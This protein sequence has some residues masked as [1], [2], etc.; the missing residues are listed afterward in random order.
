MTRRTDRGTGPSYPILKNSLSKVK[1][2]KQNK[3]SLTAL[4]TAYARAYH[5]V[6]GEAKIF[7]DHL[8]YHFFTAEERADLERNLAE[9]LKFFDPERAASCPDQASALA[10][11]MRIQGCPATISRS[12]Y[13]EDCLETAMQKGVCQYVILGAGMDTFAFRRPDLSG[14]LEVFEIDHPLTQAF[15]LSRL[16]ELGWEMPGHMHFIPVDFTK[17]NL[18][19]ALGQSS[20]DPGKL[21]F[22]SWLGVTIYLDR[23]EV[24]ATLRAIAGIAP[25]GSQVV[26]DYLDTDAFTPGKASRQVQLMR[27]IVQRVGEPLKGGFDPDALAADLA[28]AGM[29]LQENLSPSDIEKRYFLGRTDGYHA[30][31][32]MHFCLWGQA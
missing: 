26:F 14:R 8:A 30:A 23:A 7:D 18:A 15:K 13:A 1:Y 10:W 19:G 28:G 25:A 12:R 21:S 31:G 22:F 32:H 2:L 4:L 24:I 16:K 3:G 11:Y 29:V 9:S 17:E 20:Y 5:A 27:E 6:H